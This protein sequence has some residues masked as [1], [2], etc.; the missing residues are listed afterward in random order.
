MSNEDAGL[1]KCHMVQQR[2]HNHLMNILLTKR[3]EANFALNYSQW[4]CMYKS[5]ITHSDGLVIVNIH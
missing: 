5:A 4:D 1:F 2:T 3:E